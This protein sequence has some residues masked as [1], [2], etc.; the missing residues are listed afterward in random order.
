MRDVF[1]EAGK[2]KWAL[3]GLMWEENLGSR[4]SACECRGKGEIL[5]PRDLETTI[6]LVQGYMEGDKL[7]LGWSPYG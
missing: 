4:K 7:C 5:L 6:L 3:T 1:S 2:G